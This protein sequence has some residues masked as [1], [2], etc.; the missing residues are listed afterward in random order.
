[1]P[2]SPTVKIHDNL[3][4]AVF[5]VTWGE[6]V[7]FLKHLFIGDANIMGLPEVPIGQVVVDTVTCI[8][9]MVALWYSRGAYLLS[10]KAAAPEGGDVG[11]ERKRD[12]FAMNASI[13]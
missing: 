4:V 3:D 11:A 12:L 2:D 8:V 7:A 13:T 1:M 9:A 10:E 6:T 5:V